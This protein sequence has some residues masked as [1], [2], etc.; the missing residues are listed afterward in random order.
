VKPR[1]ILFLAFAILT[2]TAGA[3]VHAAPPQRATTIAVKI[4]CAG[5]ANKMVSK[6]RELPEVASVKVDLKGQT[7]V[8]V[9][10]GREAPTALAQWEA[11]EKAG[12][13]PLKLK[14]PFGEFVAKPTE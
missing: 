3:T 13:T 6:L 5:C 14:G 1:T 8:V 2:L 11:I 9:P 4:H 10:K 7:L 12:F